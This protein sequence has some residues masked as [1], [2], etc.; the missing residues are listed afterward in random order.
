MPPAYRVAEA[1]LTLLQIASMT[2]LS[3]GRAALLKRTGISC[4]SV[5][6][7]GTTNRR[8]E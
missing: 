8:H 3:V 6:N 5:S 2:M 7:G 1:A 4:L